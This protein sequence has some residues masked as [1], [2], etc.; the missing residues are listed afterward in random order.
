MVII[1]SIAISLPSVIPPASIALSF[2]VAVTSVL[3]VS[4]T[5]FPVVVSGRAMALLTV[6]PTF[7][8]KGRKAVARK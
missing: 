4:V 5:V 2:S 6:R 8:K 3:P 7:C 1:L